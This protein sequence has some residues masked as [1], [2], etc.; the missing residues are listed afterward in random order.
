MFVNRDEFLVCELRPGSNPTG[1][2]VGR[3]GA[4]ADVAQKPHI[5]RHNR[6][7]VDKW[8]QTRA[9]GA[10]EI[11]NILMPDSAS[12]ILPVR[13]FRA[14]LARAG[15]DTPGVGSADM[16]GCRSSGAVVAR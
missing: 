11:M 9:F 4:R 12:G 16:T 3:A 7:D 1:P 13:I 15:A 2:A 8:L 6:C 5:R 14:P 10:R